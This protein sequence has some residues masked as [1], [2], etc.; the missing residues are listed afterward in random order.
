MNVKKWIDFLEKVT[1]IAVAFVIIGGCV[2][3]SAY[4][5]QFGWGLGPELNE[6]NAGNVM[7][8]GIVVFHLAMFV[9]ASTFA[10]CTPLANIRSIDDIHTTEEDY[11]KTES[12][13]LY[14][15][16]V[17]TVIATACLAAALFCAPVFFL[18]LM[19]VFQT[20]VAGY[21][22]QAWMARK[23][24]IRWYGGRKENVS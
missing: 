13:G 12:Q 1:V 4:W 2:L 11:R 14:N 18:S 22:L 15:A 24:C 5:Y 16:K 8:I 19:L 6:L 3:L 7:H 21:A 10:L 9:I 23:L 20:A 17:H